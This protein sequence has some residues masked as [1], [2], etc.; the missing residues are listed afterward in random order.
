GHVARKVDHGVAFADVVV[1]LVERAA[2]G[3]DEVFLDVDADVGPGEMRAQLV[4]VALELP[5]DCGEE[6]PEVRHGS[7]WALGL[8]PWALGFRSSSSSSSSSSSILN[9]EP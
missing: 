7:C 2:A 1:Q 5:G 8:G 3:G 6:D 9:P 4:A